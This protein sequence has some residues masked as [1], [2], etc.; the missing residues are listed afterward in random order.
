M[1][2][3]LNA[4]ILFMI[5]LI[6]NMALNKFAMFYRQVHKLNFLGQFVLYLQ[7]ITLPISFN[8]ILGHVF[9]LYQVYNH[10]CSL[11]TKKNKKEILKLINFLNYFYFNYNLVIYLFN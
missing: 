11:N 10:N 7:Q 3:Y 8:F 1:Q 5:I 2:Y 6:I 9:K 4:K